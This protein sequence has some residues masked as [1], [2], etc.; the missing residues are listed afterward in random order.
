MNVSNFGMGDMLQF[1][2]LNFIMLHAGPLLT[3]ALKHGTYFYH[4]VEV[5]V[6]E[7]YSSFIKSWTRDKK[8]QNISAR[9]WTS[10][11]KNGTAVEFCRE[12]FINY[13]IE[14][15]T[16]SIEWVKHLI[17]TQPKL[18]FQSHAYVNTHIETPLEIY[19]IP[20]CSK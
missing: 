6:I 7:N 20:L 1:L 17:F 18:T 5:L 8:F 13:C 15:Y 4:S 19:F 2:G 11:T 9:T 10:L 14:L 16:L 3:P 12:I